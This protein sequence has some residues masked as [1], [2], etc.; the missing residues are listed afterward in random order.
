MKVV[1]LSLSL[2]L[3]HSAG[4]NSVVE[5]F[6]TTT[7]LD[8]G[9]AVWNSVQRAI[10][11]TLQVT[12]WRVN[13]G[14]AL[15]T[16]D[17]PVGD[18]RHGAFNASTYASF[19]S[20][21]GSTIYIDAATYPILQVTSFQLDAGY[22]LTAVG[23]GLKIY[24]LSTVEINGAILCSGSNASGSTAGTGRCGG[25]NG[26]SGGASGASGE[27]GYPRT[28]T[29]TGGFG[30]VYNMNAPGSGGG[31]GGSGSA[32]GNAGSD[33]QTTSN[34]GGPAG[35]GIADPGF[36][37]LS[38]AAGGG[39]G[40]GSGTEVG[41]GGGG[42][43]GTVIIHAVGDI[44]V[45]ASGTIKARG[46]DGGSPVSGGG[47]GGGGGGAIQLFTAGTITLTAGTPVDAT[48]GAKGIPTVGITAGSGGNGA[49]GRTWLVYGTFSG[50][51]AETPATVLNSVGTFQYANAVARTIITKAYDTRSTLGNFQS[52][53]AT[54]VS[55]DIV[56]EIA[57]SNDG[58]AADDSGW[59]PLAQVATLGQKRFVR[60]RI[61]LTNSNGANPTKV[62]GLSVTYTAGQK[63]NFDFKSSCASVHGRTPPSSSSLL[64]LFALLLIPFG[65]GFSLKRFSK[66]VHA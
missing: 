66:P 21:V 6:S 9:T 1:V 60:F 46:G 26:G 50:A 14:D 4:A 64:F 48:E 2:F 38:G 28:T 13:G 24:S 49:S 62:T 39:G 20:V 40:S 7:Y 29:I 61:T 37:N 23:G 55:G 42:G 12:G 18:G 22:T 11:P 8:S 54:P 33:N 31:G 32:N 57:G 53:S 47:G 30:G 65:L 59:L 3:Y 35:A 36:A 5:N 44:T 17:F 51:G 56:T 45:S 41:G 27:R 10:H 63:E 52:A 25:G 58:F 15:S 19:G 43:G 16:D 34:T